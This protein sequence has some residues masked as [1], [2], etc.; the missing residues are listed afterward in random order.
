MNRHGPTLMGR[1]CLARRRAEYFRGVADALEW[2]AG[3]APAA[4]LQSVEGMHPSA[5]SPP[6]GRNRVQVPVLE[7]VRTAP[8]PLSIAD[9]LRAGRDQGLD[10]TRNEVRRVLESGIAKGVLIRTGYR[11]AP[12]AGVPES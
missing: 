2:A 6:D 4:E 8:T 5:A 7:I 12:V 1:A 9:I 10:L 3:Q 11:Y